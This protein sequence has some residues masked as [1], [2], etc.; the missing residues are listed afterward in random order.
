MNGLCPDYLR[1]RLVTRDLKYLA[2]GVGDRRL[3]ATALHTTSAR[4]LAGQAIGPVNTLDCV[5][6]PRSVSFRQDT[7]TFVYGRQYLPLHY[8]HI[9][10]IDSS[11]SKD[12]IDFNCDLIECNRFNDF[13]SI[14]DSGG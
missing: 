10:E 7:A 2:I 8:F 1:G 14:L 12:M 9:S 3:R 13:Q 5:S 11:I 4:R 6:T